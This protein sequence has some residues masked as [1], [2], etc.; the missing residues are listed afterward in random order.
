MTTLDQLQMASS[1]T[2]SRPVADTH[3]PAAA[4]TAATVLVCGGATGGHLTPG[5]SVAR[6]LTAAR[7]GTRVVFVLT[8]RDAEQRFVLDPAFERHTVPAVPW[9]R[10]LRA[11]A[12]FPVR[13]LRVRREGRRCIR[14]FA[15]SVAVGLG[16]YGQYGPIRAAQ[17]AGVFTVLLEQNARPGKANRMLA[18]RAGLVCCQWAATRDH[19]PR[20]TPVAVTGNPVRASILAAEPQSGWR[21]FG[22]VEGRTTLLVLGG[23]QGSLR[24]NHAMIAALRRRPDLAERCQIIHQT[25]PHAGDAVAAAYQARHWPCHVTAF[26]SEAEMADALACADLVVARAGA[27]TA[28]ELTAVGRP[29]IL[30]PLPTAD[31]HQEAN[32][33]VLAAA[34]AARVVAD[35]GDAEKSGADLAENLCALCADHDTLSVMA[36]GSRHLGVRDAAQRVADAILSRLDRGTHRAHP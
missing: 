20:G 18:R 31:R 10:S 7:P 8:G 17:E 24:L 21:R 14:A 2:A 27:T 12:R 23:S 28:A 26:L 13:W 22:L 30:F 35:S 5:L 9:P 4:G 15:P 32:A 29:A 11:L 25:G 19:L 6:A 36:K 3:A 16:G 33:Q 1:Q 34:G